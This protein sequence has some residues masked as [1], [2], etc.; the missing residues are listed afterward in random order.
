MNQNN[1]FAPLTD[2][3]PDAVLMG[4]SI[5]VSDEMAASLRHDMDDFVVRSLVRGVESEL[6]HL[7]RDYPQKAAQYLEL[8]KITEPAP[9]R[10]CAP[11]GLPAYDCVYRD[12]EALYNL[13]FAIMHPDKLRELEQNAKRLDEANETIRDL[14]KQLEGS[15]ELAR[16][17]DD[18]AKRYDTIVAALRT[19]LDEPDQADF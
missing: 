17:N 4:S 5:L 8:K 16:Q 3:R 13:R 6:A 2:V 14:R 12:A 18:K 19:K 9:L 10:R 1:R 15:R 7:L 11:H